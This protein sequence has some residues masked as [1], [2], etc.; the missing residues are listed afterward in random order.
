MNEEKTNSSTVGASSEPAP[1]GVVPTKEEIKK[2][3]ASAPAENGE[4]MI[5]ISK[6]ALDSIL[7]RLEKVEEDNTLRAKT[8]SKNTAIKIEELRRQ[9]KLLKTVKLRTF[10]GKFVVKYD[11]IKNEVYFREGRLIENQI[12]GLYFKGEERPEEVQLREWA[13][14]SEY[15]PLE[16]TR[17]SKDGNG[18]V[19]LTVRTQEGEEFEVNVKYVN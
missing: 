17:E 10:H 18:D 16:V 11:T 13:T 19:Y 8:D 1:I 15:V 9:G 14:Q 7:T 4:E 2:S 3:V 6:N 12:V 5:T